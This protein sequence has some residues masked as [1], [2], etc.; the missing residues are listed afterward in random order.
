MQYI[1]NKTDTV[2]G[3]EIPRGDWEA[4]CQQFSRDHQE[5]LVNVAQRP[6][7]SGGSHEALEF[8]LEA[9]TLH[10]DH[11]EEVLSIVVRKDGMTKKHLYKSIGRPSRMMVEGTGPDVKL[12]VDSTDGSTTTIRFRRVATPDYDSA[13]RNR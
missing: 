3:R 10:L 11:A 7:G 5:W 9:L 13:A 2:Q 4:F 8:P 1:S 12:H 6:G